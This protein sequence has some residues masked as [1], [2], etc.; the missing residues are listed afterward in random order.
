MP[1]NG[2]A[3]GMH[4]FA[5]LSNNAYVGIG[6]NAR[7]QLW[8]LGNMYDITPQVWT[9]NLSTGFSTTTGSSLVTVTDASYAPTAGDYV[10][11]A[12]MTYVGGILLQGAYQ[13]VDVGVG[14]ANTYRIQ[15]NQIATSN[16][17]SG[18]NTLNF[19]TTNTS[20]IVT[21]T[22]AGYTFT[23][24]QQILVTV[25]TTVAT[26]AIQGDYYLT[27]SGGIATFTQGTSANATTSGYENSDTV[28]VIYGPTAAPDPNSV[29]YGSGL[30]SEG[31]YGYSYA[32][33]NTIRQW[34]L[35]NWGSFLVGSYTGGPPYIW[36]PPIGASV[37][38]NPA[39]LITPNG[40]SS[41]YVPWTATGLFVAMP[42]RQ[43]II[44]GTDV[45]LVASQGS[46]QQDPLLIRFSD[47]SDYTS[48]YPTATNQAGSYRL[49]S[50][51]KII[52]AQQAPLQ[53]LIWTDIELWSMQYLQ[54]PLVYG[55]TK[56]GVGC[57]LISLR[58]AG[59][60]GPLNEWM[61]QQGFFRYDGS[62]VSPLRC[63]VWDVVF[64]PNGL[65]TNY[66]DNVFCAANSYFNELA[67]F[68]PTIGSNGAVTTYVKHNVLDDV[69]DYGT[70][71]RT[72]WIDQ[73]VVGGPVAMD[74][75]GILQQ[76][77]TS[78]DMDSQIM[79][80]WA[81]SGW[82]SLQ[83]G[84]N[85]LSIQ[86][87][88]PEFKL[89]PGATAYITVFTVAYEG[90]TPTQYGPYSVTSTTEYFIVKARGRLARI[91]VGSNGFSSFWRLGK[92]LRLMAPAGKR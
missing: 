62:T 32:G 45:T 36:Q 58:A 22:L 7:L 41:N 55:F 91:Q 46:A 50:G 24:Y 27:V 72:D 60:M 38:N 78:N 26:V 17:A 13:V 20:K 14:G 40:Y 87:I 33:Y 15:S 34:S 18:G 75:N 5:D 77:E 19:A 48:W 4:A 52:G 80:S 29:G 64:G 74:T 73:S 66:L 35:D 81:L 67:W 51:S 69:W 92:C 56:I 16:V 21:V 30:Y 90:D 70:L 85:F 83:E 49:P 1:V 8:N 68:I 37:Y 82:F 61:S 11:I 84:D 86:R 6:T 47:V 2:T 28:E 12:T 54:F 79:N 44:F 57:G 39:A 76:H 43:L 89:S 88:L 71:T 10:I 65:D 63:T 42:Q 53:A 59:K 9:S 23:N 31:N 3:R 25:L